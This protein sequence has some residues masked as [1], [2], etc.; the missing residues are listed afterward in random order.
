M[1]NTAMLI[2]IVFYLIICPIIFPAVVAFFLGI[3][4]NALKKRAESDKKD[5]TPKDNQP[6][7]S[8]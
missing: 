2:K 1:E 4:A 7:P 3:L 8:N 6:V 5:G